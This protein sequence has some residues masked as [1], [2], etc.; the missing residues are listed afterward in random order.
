M[1]E[2]P[3][4]EQVLDDEYRD[5]LVEERTE[6]IGSYEDGLVDLQK[7]LDLTISNI[8]EMDGVRQQ[9]DENN[10]IKRNLTCTPGSG[11]KRP[12]PFQ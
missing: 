10:N 9:I 11:L 5:V 3:T 7:E 4:C 12:C 8:E 6:K 2:C 1:K